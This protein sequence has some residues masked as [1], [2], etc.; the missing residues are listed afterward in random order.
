L[1]SDDELPSLEVLLGGLRDPDWETR[2]DSA[3]ALA[4]IDRLPNQAVEA[5]A[6]AARDPGPQVRR[7]AVGTLGQSGRWLA[8][9]VIVGALEDPVASV[10]EG[11][12]VALSDLGAAGI[13][14]ENAAGALLDRLEDPSPRVAYTA[15][16]ALGWQG[17]S[18]AN[19]V[20]AAFRSSDWGRHVWRV[21]TAAA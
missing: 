4:A 14:G 10:R 11:A 21:L 9:G 7:A 3:A 5:L 18:A 20:R 16:W 12:C 17:G 13:T 8:L 2:F 19:G 6:I 15:Y 1:A